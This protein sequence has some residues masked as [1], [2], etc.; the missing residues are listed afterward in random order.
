VCSIAWSPDG[1][2]IASGSSDK[3]VR[4]WDLLTSQC[5]S[6]LDGHSDQINLLAWSQDGG[7]LASGSSDKTVRIWNPITGQRLSRL[8]VNSLH[9][10]KIGFN[11]LR[12]KFGTFNLGSAVSISS[13]SPFRY[14]ES[15][16]DWHGLSGDN[17][18]ITYKGVN[19]L[20]L[21]VE[22]RPR[23]SAQFAIFAT[24]M[25]IGCSSGRVIFLTLSSKNNSLFETSVESSLI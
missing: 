1:S 18:W 2:L 5:I 3:T 4:I 24:T 8:Q 17:S 10:K 23:S 7:Q 19:L 9:S 14:P 25:A 13:P 16:E 15:S 6:I 11:N 21:P 22:Y 12:T 20:W